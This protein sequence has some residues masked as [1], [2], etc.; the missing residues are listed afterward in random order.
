[1]RLARGNFRGRLGFGAVVG[2]SLVEKGLIEKGL[3]D[4]RARLNRFATLR[5]VVVAQA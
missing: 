1:M 5:S 3:V 4:L 2:R